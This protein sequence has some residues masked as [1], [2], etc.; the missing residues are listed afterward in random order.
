MGEKNFPSGTG[1]ILATP[2]LPP[3]EVGGGGR[4]SL[5]N[6]LK[7]PGRIVVFVL[8]LAVRGASSKPIKTGLNC[9]Q[10]TITA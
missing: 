4:E 1:A 2:P 7:F 3:K 10:D 6:F 8:F 5:H 9:Q